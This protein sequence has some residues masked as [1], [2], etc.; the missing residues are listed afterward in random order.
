MTRIVRD[1]L[2]GMLGLVIAVIGFSSQ[3]LPLQMPSFEVASVKQSNDRS[4]QPA[5]RYT[6]SGVDFAGVPLTW[7]I[8]EAYQL[9]YYSPSAISATDN[10]V[11]E[12][13]SF[14]NRFDI[15]ARAESAVSRNVIRLMLQSLLV[16]RFKLTLHHESKDESVYRLVVGKSGLRL[17]ASADQSEVGQPVIANSSAVYDFRHVDMARLAGFLSTLLDRRV[18]DSTGLK[19]FYDFALNREEAPQDKSTTAPQDKSTTTRDAVSS[20]IPAGIE[21]QLGL[22]LEPARAPVDHVVIDHLEKPSEN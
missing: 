1:T 18:V 17:R 16:E 15:S 8:G 4:V 13:L 3:A 22:K 10:A 7:I 12:L 11:R 21:S 6:P 2:G 9:P 14:T 5:L 20:S 19:E